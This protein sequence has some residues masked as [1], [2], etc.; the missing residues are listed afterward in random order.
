MSDSPSN[1]FARAASLGHTIPKSYPSGAPILVNYMGKKQQA[2][3]LGHLGGKI[4]VRTNDGKINVMDMEHVHGIPEQEA[5][6]INTAIEMA[7]NAAKKAG[8]GVQKISP[9]KM[10]P[11][12]IQPK[13]QPIL[14]KQGSIFPKTTSILSNP[15]SLS[16]SQMP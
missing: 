11:S 14:A 9:P 1:L 10:A 15:S 7:Q 6:P 12:A 8:G 16:R 2:V 4:K 5:K 3:H 13:G